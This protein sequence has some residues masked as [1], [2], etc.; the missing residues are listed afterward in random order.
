MTLAQQNTVQLRHATHIV[1][2]DQVRP[3][4]RQVMRLAATHGRADSGVL[5]RKQPTESAALFRRRQ[6]N[7][8]GAF[9]VG[10]E[11][12]RLLVDVKIPQ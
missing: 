3:T 1:Y 7:D 12:T 11:G 4:C 8:R 6:V 9:H 10:E 5:D 2:G